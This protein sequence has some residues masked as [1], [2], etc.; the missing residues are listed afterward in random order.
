MMLAQTMLLV[1]KTFPSN[2]EAE[3]S[4]PRVVI[5]PAKTETSSQRS[6]MVVGEVA[7][8]RDTRSTDPVDCT[9][10]LA[11][12]V[13]QDGEHRDPEEGQ[14]DRPQPASPGSGLRS[15][16]LT[17]GEEHDGQAQ[18]TRPAP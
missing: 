2:R 3:S 14:P 16:V 1:P 18:T 13:Q 6:R 10:R 9:Q 4:T 11:L 8:R 15:G 7:G 5:P 17:G 12:A